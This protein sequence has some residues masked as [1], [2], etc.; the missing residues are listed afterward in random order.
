[1]DMVSLTMYSDCWGSMIDLQDGGAFSGVIMN[2]N[3]KYIYLPKSAY[4]QYQT[5]V[6]DYQGFAMNMSDGT[7]RSLDWPCDEYNSTLYFGLTADIN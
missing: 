6:M 1:M 3:S 2:P 7:Y 5:K 4:L